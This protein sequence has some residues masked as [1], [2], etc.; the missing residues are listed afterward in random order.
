[1]KSSAC[2]SLMPSGHSASPVQ[3]HARVRESS[4]IWR[5]PELLE[6]H[7]TVLCDAQSVNLFT[8]R[9][10]DAIQSSRG[11]GAFGAARGVDMFNDAL[12]RRWLDTRRVARSD[13]F[14]DSKHGGR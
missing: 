11:R 13:R 8:N 14:N 4:H 7:H 1:V 12:V 9:Y 10:P 2:E 6:E 5:S 3:L